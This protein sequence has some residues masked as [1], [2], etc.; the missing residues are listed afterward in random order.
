ML[1]DEP[2]LAGGRLVRAIVTEGDLCPRVLEDRKELDMDRR[3]TP[4]RAAFPILLCE[5][6]LAGDSDAWI[7][8]RRLPVRPAEPNDIVVIGDTGCRMV[9]WEIQAC[10]SGVDWPFA[11][12]ATRAAEA[13]K[14]SQS[15]ILHVGDFHYRENPCA[16][17]NR[18]CGGSPFGDTWATWENEFFKPAAPLLLAAPWVIARGNHEN[19]DRAG[20][21][22]LYFFALPGQRKSDQACENDL[23]SYSLDIG[24]TADKRR[25]VLVVL[26]TAYQDNKYDV[27]DRCRK[28]GNW[29][30]ALDRSNSE[31][32]LTLHQPL[33]QRNPDGSQD[34]QGPDFAPCKNK[35]T[36]SALKVI[37]EKFASAKP[38]RLARL[39]LSGDTHLFQLFR[40]ADT[41]APYMPV[42][43]VAGNG[44]TKLDDLDPLVP[45]PPASSSGGPALTSDQN[46]MVNSFGVI[47]S[48]WTIAKHGFTVLHRDDATW[49]VTALDANGGTM[50]SCRFSELPT[51]APAADCSGVTSATH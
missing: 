28:F 12:V 40:P 32:W 39:V 43:L 20:A 24:F 42:Q 26:D 34:V 25:R 41:I 27:E 8:S 19:C 36:K 7:G 22:W 46:L 21:G 16:D 2:H 45:P 6:K 5:R 13:V 33:W 50:A 37:R 11:A 17:T 49:T 14:P 3:A 4:V 51:A 9:H 29:L 31:V 44:G 35:E 23:E 48:A 15:F 47:G 10:L 1:P 18:E 30:T 38:K